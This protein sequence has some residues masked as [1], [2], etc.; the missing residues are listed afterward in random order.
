MGD[1]TDTTRENSRTRQQRRKTAVVPLT[2]W[3]DAEEAERALRVAYQARLQELREFVRWL[4]IGIADRRRWQDDDLVASYGEARQ[5]TQGQIRRMQ[6]IL[7]QIDA[8]RKDEET[9][10]PE[11]R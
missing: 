3:G 8:R 2:A 6:R 11:W 10:A 4:N 9:R 5:F 1:R 7:N